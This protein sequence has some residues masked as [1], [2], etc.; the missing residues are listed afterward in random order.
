MNTPMKHRLFDGV[1]VEY[2]ACCLLL[3]ACRSSLTTGMGAAIHAN[4]STVLLANSTVTGN[5][6][7]SVGGCAI[8]AANARGVVLAG[9]T[10][11]RNKCEG[12]GGTLVGGNYAASTCVSGGAS[13]RVTGSMPPFEA[14]NETQCSLAPQH[15]VHISDSTFAEDV[16]TPYSCGGSI[17][18]S[19]AWLELQRSSI[20]DNT[21]ANR[22]GAVASIDSAIVLKD[23]RVTNHSSAFYGGSVF[24][25]R[26]RFWATRSQFTDALTNREG[27]GC[28]YIT[29]ATEVRVSGCQFERCVGTQAGEMSGR[30]SS[31]GFLGQHAGVMQLHGH[32]C[33]PCV[34]ND[35]AYLLCWS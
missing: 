4:S 6:G 7:A 11:G 3:L 27:G 1:C 8:N 10:F 17:M 32:V 28:V 9:C 26:G 14:G 23:S 34:V 31:V 21:R 19:A 16:P 20:T 24:Q 33:S 12:D 15:L 13:L 30:S 18:L 35:N 22:G 25:L 29:D 2:V 5:T